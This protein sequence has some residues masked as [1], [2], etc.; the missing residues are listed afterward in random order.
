MNIDLGKE[1]LA[2]GFENKLYVAVAMIW[3]ECVSAKK[4]LFL[5]DRVRY[6]Y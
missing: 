3:E 6:W 5:E 4:N 1:L 2:M